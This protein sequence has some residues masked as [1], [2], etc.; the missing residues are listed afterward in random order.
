MA[1]MHNGQNDKPLLHND[2]WLSKTLNMEQVLLDGR[3]LSM[4]QLAEIPQ[5]IRLKSPLL[6]RAECEDGLLHGRLVETQQ[7]LEMAL[8]GFAA[9]A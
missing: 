7:L 8:K 2:A 3:T 1:R 6:L 4:E 5:D 9:Q